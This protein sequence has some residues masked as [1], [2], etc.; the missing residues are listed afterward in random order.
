VNRA[1]AACPARSIEPPGRPPSVALARGH[2]HRLPVVRRLVHSMSSAATPSSTRS[3]VGTSATNETRRWSGLIRAVPA[4]HRA[5][6]CVAAEVHVGSH[7][8]RMRKEAMSAYACRS[9]DGRALCC[10]RVCSCFGLPLA[11]CRAAAPIVCDLPMCVVEPERLVRVGCFTVEC[12]DAEAG[13]VSRTP[14]IL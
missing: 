10:I 14:G 6:E 3:R 4:L 5:R 8:P 12:V 1:R 7:E 9:S 13:A 2:A 11:L